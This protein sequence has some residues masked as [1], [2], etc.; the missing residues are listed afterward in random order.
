MKMSF[1]GNTLPETLG[2]FRI[3]TYLVDLVDTI[4]EAHELGD[5]M[6]ST[7]I[8]VEVRTL[9]TIQDLTNL[10]KQIGEENERAKTNAKKGELYRKKIVTK[11]YEEIEII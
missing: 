4:K 11:V 7:P 6:D 3:S 9:N 10:T 5:E 8:E 2:D 1:N